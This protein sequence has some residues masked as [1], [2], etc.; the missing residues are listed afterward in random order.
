MTVFRLLVDLNSLVYNVYRAGRQV[1]DKT[2]ELSAADR[3]ICHARLNAWLAHSTCQE[4]L[5]A[6][7]TDCEAHVEIHV[8]HPDTRQAK[9]EAVL[10]ARYESD[11][12]KLAKR[13][14]E[15]VLE[16]KQKKKLETKARKRRKRKDDQRK[17]REHASTSNAMIEDEELLPETLRTSDFLQC[18][19]RR[20]LLIVHVL[21][22]N[23]LSR[24]ILLA[25]SLFP[26]VRS[27]Y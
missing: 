12:V 21:S 6:V 25:G 2:R 4:Y 26:H 13:L 20:A 1:I 15:E 22:F 23:I 9:K 11:A 16:V 17:R 27:H 5:Q 3:K 18:S 24:Q 8:D 7:P 19:L 14:V 10:E